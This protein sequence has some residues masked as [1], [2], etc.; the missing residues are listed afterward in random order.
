MQFPRTLPAYSAMI[1]DHDDN[2]WVQTFPSSRD[3][4]A[5]WVGFRP[6]GAALAQ[7]A[8]PLN[9]EVSEIGP[10][11]VLGTE[12]DRLTGITRV[13]RFALRRP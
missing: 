2:L 11:D 8:L 10:D 7:L 4:H 9:L 3:T 6:T 13:K 12:T 1:V 5:N